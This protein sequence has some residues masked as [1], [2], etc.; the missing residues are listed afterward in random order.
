MPNPA[1]APIAGLLPYPSSKSPQS[2]DGFDWQLGEN[3]SARS[4]SIRPGAP[5]GEE[6]HSMEVQNFVNNPNIAFHKAIR[7]L[8]SVYTA[9]INTLQFEHAKALSARGPSSSSPSLKP[10]SLV[11]ALESSPWSREP[12]KETRLS[13][14]SDTVEAEDDFGQQDTHISGIDQ[15]EESMKIHAKEK[16]DNDHEKLTGNEGNGENGENRHV[17]VMSDEDGKPGNARSIEDIFRQKKSLE[18]SK[19]RIEKVTQS[20]KFEASIVALILINTIMMVLE[21][22]YWGI[23]L[24]NDLTYPGSAPLNPKEWPSAKEVFDASDMIIGIIFTLELLLKVVSMRFGFMTSLWNLFDV[25]VV[26]AWLV[27]K[28]ISTEFGVNPTIL[29]LGRLLRI[30]RVVRL[31]KSIQ[32]LDSLHILIGS[33]RASLAILVWSSILLITLITLVALLVHYLLEDFM[34]DTD[35]TLVKRQEVY[36]YFGTFTRAVCTL[37]EATLGNF[38][39]PMRCLMNNVDESWGAAF[40]VY[41]CV[42][43]FAIVRVISGVFLH[44]TFRIANTDDE[45]MV[46]K[47]TRELDMHTK[48]MNQLFKA[49]DPEGKGVLTY[50]EFVNLMSVP[51]VSS[52]M[53]AYELN[54]ADLSLVFHLVD[55]GDG[56]ITAKE[57]VEGVA[58][59]KGQ[60]KSLDLHRMIKDV[61]MIKCFVRDIYD[62][63]SGMGKTNMT[64][65]AVKNKAKKSA[66]RA[67][68]FSFRNSAHM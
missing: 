64:L 26:I 58:R 19:S 15:I 8:L 7:E 23:L 54:V 14:G 43:G 60:A 32:A 49:A 61:I 9:D 67:S 20:W 17:S 44:E 27:S 41:K 24:G 6:P 55:D 63:L 13:T 33:I 40:L 56:T 28:L 31:F 45:V 53:A 57:L 4:P 35:E 68:V 37:F 11:G 38:S 3:G 34:K 29:R 12:S 66:G 36:G 47:R 42:V 50:E 51:A 22:Q 2:M 62:S 5:R 16:A 10:H 48:K 59:L 65:D 25:I 46:R 39:P 1:N 52:W 30:L 21:V 18:R